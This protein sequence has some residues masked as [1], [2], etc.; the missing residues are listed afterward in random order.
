MRLDPRGW[1]N[2]K[3][4]IAHGLATKSDPPA[5][6]EAQII[7]CCAVSA[8]SALMWPGLRLDK[9]RFI[10][11]LVEFAPPGTD[12]RTVSVPILAERLAASRRGPD[13][14]TLRA[15]FLPRLET[16]VVAASQI[17]QTEHVIQALLPRLPLATIRNSSY[18]AIIYTDLRC[19]LVHEY[20]LSEALSSFGMSLTPHLPSYANI[21]EPIRRADV[22]DAAQVLGVSLSTARRRIV[23]TIRR[24]HIPYTYLRDTLRGTASN[25]CDFWDREVH[26]ERA[27]PTPWWI[28]P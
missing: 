2:S 18:A 15:Q 3:L 17:D 25:A 21:T 11:F 16:K 14:A 12:L 28:S 13:A 1:F 20:R 10:Q 26:F 24:L 9:K 27:H 23:R 7:L 6:I 8:L 4:R 5:Q 19:A 22:A